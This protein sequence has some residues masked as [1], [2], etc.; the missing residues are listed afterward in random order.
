MARKQPKFLSEGQTASLA[1]TYM[2]K[3]SSIFDTINTAAKLATDRQR[4]HVI[5]PIREQ[6]A[7]WKLE[8][9]ISKST[10]NE[11]C[12]KLGINNWDDVADG[13]QGLRDMLDDARMQMDMVRQAL[14]VSVEPH[15]SLFNRILGRA[16]LV[17]KLAKP[18]QSKPAANMLEMVDPTGEI[19]LVSIDFG[20]NQVTVKLRHPIAEIETEGTDPVNAYLAMAMAMQKMKV[21]LAEIGVTK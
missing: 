1:S 3:E 6:A 2:A 18:D 12:A 21:A 5:E 7:M 10:V 9:R 13:V 11:V 16:T 19:Q 14:G 17:G 4:V 8:A 20:I 15:Q